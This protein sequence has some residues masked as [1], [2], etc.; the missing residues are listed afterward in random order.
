MVGR[1]AGKVELGH[2]IL[3]FVGG[4]K[5]FRFCPECKGK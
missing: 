1:E 3:V 5:D 4:G 2:V